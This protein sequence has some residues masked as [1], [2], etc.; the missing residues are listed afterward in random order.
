MVYGLLRA[1]PGDRA[2]L[3]PSPQGARCA[4]QELGIS[5]GMPGPHG[6]AVRIRVV[7]PPANS[8][9]QPRLRPPHPAFNARDDRETP[10]LIERGTRARDTDFGKNERR[11]F[12]WVGLDRGDGVEEVSEISFLAQGIFGRREV[13]SWAAT[14][15]IESD[16]PVGRDASCLRRPGD[17]LSGVMAGLVP[18]IHAFRQTR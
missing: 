4:L 6:L 9:R 11:I 2:F 13:S 17:A 12:F 3:P 16:L 18:A 14:S 10:L 5:V 8:A 1:L 15:K 7:R